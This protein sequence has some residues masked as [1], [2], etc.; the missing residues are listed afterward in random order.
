MAEAGVK[1]RS[2]GGTGRSAGGDVSLPVVGEDRRHIR[3]SK[4]GPRRAAVLI[5]VHVIIGVHV[6]LWL[7]YGMTI[8]P[9][10]PSE[11]MYT[12]EKG[13][14]NAGF[15]FFVLAIL[16]TLVFGR[17][18][19]GWGCHVVALQDLCGW[20]MKKAGVHPKPFRSRLLILAP[21]ALALYMFVWPTFRREALAPA[22][23]AAGTEMPAWLGVAG[24]R[25]ELHNAFVVEDFWATF[26]P[27]YVAVPFLGV[28][29]FAAVYFL[30]AKG[31]CSYGCPYGGFFGPADMVATGRI[32]VNE[33][34]EG[35][36]HCTAVCTSNVRVH[37]EV[38][39]YGMVIDPGCMK[40]L[41]CVS[42][43][44]NSA[45]RFGFAAPPVFNARAREGK[46]KAVRARHFD[47]S[48]RGE[49]VVGVVFLGLFLGFRGMFDLVPMLMAM[50]LAGIGAFGAWKLW[51]L[52]R[53]P[54]VRLQ[55]LQLRYRGR[56]TRAG[57]VF[58][59]AAALVLAAGAWGAAVNYNLWR[60]RLLDAAIETP[61]S[62]YL[63]A[64]YTPSADVRTT[65]EAAVRHFER[66]GSWSEGGFGWT[67]SADIN[68]RL[69]SLHAIC[70]RR[71]EA[72]AVLRRSFEQREP[73]DELIAY[74]LALMQLRG[75]SID[76]VA[77]LYRTIGERHPGHAGV[78]VGLAGIELM[79][80]RP[81]EAARLCGLVLR[82]KT[83]NAR[84]LL[85][86][87]AILLETGRGAESVG[88]AERAV[89]A[90]P[91]SGFVRAELARFLFLTGRA[92]ES[93]ARMRE[94][95]QQEPNNAEL[96][97]AAG[98]LFAAAGRTEEA[99]AMNQ[100]AADLERS[101]PSDSVPTERGP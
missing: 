93:V 101:G 49:L 97:R 58:A 34:C 76:D 30:G 92:D 3:K 54:N 83:R 42:V 15:V 73:T 12:L 95:V 6:L 50:G 10:E 94:A 8:S 43:C 87:A 85:A 47:L 7:W 46:K 44:P 24:A 63:T 66:A 60:G 25:P 40:C 11:S 98:E 17:I 86:A 74:L 61:A 67:R 26:P 4:N 19:C 14:V 77:G 16:S 57:W 48:L 22:F 23:R 2:C 82:G 41:D 75:A 39:D 33:D 32:L 79:R 28:C 62:E 5:A 38:R 68:L 70:G 69:A 51:C 72:E 27:W 55:S 37:E 81:E 35:C 31:F 84:V 91:H 52:V 20:L 9:V 36:G 56:W 1:E 71:A 21:L 53:V 59:P 18:F 45:L 100:R 99:A 90:E 29:G 88:A 64:G 78:K 80:G 96:H 65:A 89:E 13:E